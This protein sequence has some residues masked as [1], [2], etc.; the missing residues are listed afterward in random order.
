MRR[1]GARGGGGGGIYGRAGQ[2]PRGEGGR[3]QVGSMQSGLPHAPCRVGYICHLRS[4]RCTAVGVMPPAHTC[5]RVT[6]WSPPL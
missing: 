5:V 1:H 3:R 6:G 4:P 2:Q